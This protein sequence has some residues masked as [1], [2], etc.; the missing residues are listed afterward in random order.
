MRWL[1]RDKWKA[2]IAIAGIMLLLVLTVWVPVSAAGA[3]EGASGLATLVTVTVRAT[4]TVDA[5]GTALS[6]EQ[7]TQ[8]IKQL[9][10]QNDRSI[11]AW[12]W[13]VS[14]TLGTIV[15]ALLA[16][17]GV[18]VTIVVNFRQ[19]TRSQKEAHNKDL[20]DHKA[21]RERR[22]EEQKRWLEDHKAER[23]RQDEEQQRW[24]KDQVAE[25]EKRAEERFQSVVAGLG[26]E[27]EEAKVGAAIML[28]TFLQPGYKQFYRQ[29]FDLTVA[30]LRL[31]PVDPNTPAPRDLN[32][33]TPLD[34]SE[35]VPLDPLSQ[36]LITVFKESFPLA[37]K[38][39]MDQEKSQ[40][41]PQSLD[42]S[43]IRLDNA[44]LVE[45]DLKGIWMR[46]AFLIKADLRKAD[47]SEARLTKTCFGRANLRGTNLCKAYLYKA[48][49]R[50]A[51]LRGAYLRGAILRKADLRGAHLRGAHFNG[52]NLNEADLNGAHLRGAD[53]RTVT[54]LTK[55]QLEYCK[56]N[57]AIIDEDSKISPPQPPVSP[58]PPSQ[59]NDA[60]APSAP[61]A[62]GS[63]PT[64][65]IGRNGD[66]SSKS[67][68]ES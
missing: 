32:A 37:C 46:E 10:L 59:S 22:D 60:Q 2:G 49:L 30:H 67:D 47:L 68:S 56:A 34:P 26:S 6:K 23:E 19:S 43:R 17:A 24:L 7:L 57:G 11:A 20:E 33:P 66:P 50:G 31:R 14:A 18:L 41:D 27:R 38:A 40:F 28:R 13:N 3:Y 51:Y 64:S 8:Q 53:L 62:Q 16:V 29:S 12:F 52:A 54:G 15:A 55:E 36:A 4:P 5:T 58:P 61:P 39:L 25:R 1:K 21:E 45:S 65:D 48:D 44:Y 9:Q 35:S 63:V 42:A